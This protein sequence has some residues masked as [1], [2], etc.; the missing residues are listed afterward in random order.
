[1]AT[2]DE[3]TASL[4][5]D[6]TVTGVGTSW[7]KPLTLI[8]VGATMIFNTSPISIVTIAEVLSD[9]S[10]RAFNEKGFTAP[11]GT[12]Y[13]IL[14]HD[15]ITVEGLAQNVAETLRYYQSQNWV[16]AD[17][18][19]NVRIEDGGTGASDAAGARSKLGLGSLATMSNVPLANGGT[20]ATDA[21]GARNNLE[22]G[23]LATEDV[24]SINSGGTGATSAEG[25]RNNLELGS[26]ST[27]NVGGN[28]GNAMRVGD[29]GLGR[30]D[31]AMVFNTTSQDVLL[32]GL[33]QYGLTVFRNNQQIAAPWDVWNYSSNLFFRAGDTY[34]M[35]SIPFE[36]SGKVKVF[37][38]AA[39]SGWKTGRTLLDST[40][41]TV[42]S[43][44]FIKQASP[45]VKVF[46][47]GKYEVNEESEGAIVE[48]VSVGVYRISGV[49]GLNS[50]A[51]WGGVNGGFEIPLDINK[52]AR[53]WIDYKVEPEGSIIL[54]TY[55]RTYESS[56]SFATNKIDGFNN[57]D[58]ID[59]PSDAFISVRVNMP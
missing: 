49:L 40:I 2:Y 28:S 37:G 4:A 25:A 20:G 26:A 57:G 23:Q 3:G 10:I 38:G 17:E 27:L 41:T 32:A 22:L 29:F 55:H 50:D 33:D 19:G 9:T 30:P 43:N 46:G 1:M 59:I 14:A 39:G 12:Q 5:A 35:L 15:G 34:S 21:A 51:A 56:P 36:Q 16:L 13:F 52:Q 45:I 48:R 47:D 6:G 53:V 11:A 42:D 8:R 18:N 31:G 44:G 7:R 58:P 24:A 54:K